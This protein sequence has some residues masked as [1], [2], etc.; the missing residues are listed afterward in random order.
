MRILQVTLGFY[1]AQNWGGPV[2]IVYENSKELVRRGHQVT[3]YCTNLLNKVEKIQPGTFERNMDGIRVVYMDTINFS[4]WP[5]TLGPIWIPDLVSYLNR[6]IHNFDVLHLNGYRSPLILIPA[7]AARRMRK[8]FVMQPHGTMQVIINTFFLKRVYDRLLG[9]RELDGVGALIAL[10]ESE[11]AQALAYGIPEKK[12]EIVPNGLALNEFDVLPEKGA[13]R[14]KY[15]IDPMKTMILFLGRIN[16]KKGADMLVNAYASMDY[17]NTHLVIAGPDDGQLD[18]V[19]SLIKKNNLGSS[20]TITGLLTGA[21]VNAAFYDADLFVLPC[22]TD[23]F[24]TTIMEAC[25]M[26]TP[27]VITDRCENAHLVR[28]RVADVVPYETH[29]FAD[30][31]KNLLADRDRYSRYKANCKDILVDT[32]SVQHVVDLLEDLYQRVIVENEH[33]YRGSRN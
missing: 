21:D 5:G 8:P 17:P 13:F 27:M 33:L 20:V 11:R 29:A 6:E 9:K 25:L 22:R 24:P 28:G 32:F 18:E 7:Q 3:V 30:G 14:R 23:T 26:G 1:P 19:K 4:W 16:K 31:M 10:Q 12:I 2:K 15:Q